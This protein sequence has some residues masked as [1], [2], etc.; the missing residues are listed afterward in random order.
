LTI[1]LS[2]LRTVSLSPCSLCPPPRLFHCL[3]T[4]TPRSASATTAFRWTRSRPFSVLVCACGPVACRGQ[5]C[6]TCTRRALPP[7]AVWNAKSRQTRHVPLND[8]ATSVLRR[9][10]AQSEN[11]GRVFDVT[12]GFRTAWENLL[13]RARISQ[14]RWHDLRH[15]FAS[16]LVQRGVP[17]NTV[18]D[19]LG[20][21][22]VQMS[23]GYPHLDLELCRR[24]RVSQ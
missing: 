14:F 1:C 21:S 7:A 18:W 6:S 10:R 13:K 9:W 23:L 5:T 12:T 11:S 15:H 20:H 17:L 8:E 24:S 19:L 4:R 2:H 22:S 16:R 3:P